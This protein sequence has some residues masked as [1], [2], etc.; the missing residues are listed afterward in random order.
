MCVLELITLVQTVVFVFGELN[1]PGSWG[2]LAVRA[3]GLPYDIAKDRVASS[4]K[5]CGRGVLWRGCGRNVEI[6]EDA[7]A[8]GG[9]DG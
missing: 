3:D 5:S 2:D 1:N 7:T 9:S 8:R 4:A 6:S